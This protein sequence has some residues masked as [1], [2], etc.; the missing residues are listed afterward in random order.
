MS[1]FTS[2]DFSFID[3]VRTYA[4]FESAIAQERISRLLARV[5]AAINAGSSGSAV[6][7]YQGTSGS[8]TTA[9]GALASVDV[10]V[11]GATSGSKPVAQVANYAGTTGL[12]VAIAAI[13]ATGK[14]TVTVLNMHAT[15]ALN[16]VVTLNVHR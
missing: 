4:G 11:A 16:G 3:Y 1:I 6:Q 8:L 2:D 12:P 9:A 7:A 14:V 15:E 10:T 5:L 13:G